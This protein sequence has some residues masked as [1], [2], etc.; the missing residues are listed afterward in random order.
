MAESREPFKEKFIKDLKKED[1][2]VSLSGMIV[3]KDKDS[4]MIDDGTGQLGVII[5]DFDSSLEY[6]RVF[7][8]LVQENGEFKLQGDVIQDIKKIDKFLYNKVKQL[9]Q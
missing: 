9:L 1:G 7:G 2:F 3:D 6:V 8:R 5:E 4:F